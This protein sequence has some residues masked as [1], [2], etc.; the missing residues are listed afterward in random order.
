MWV[1][2]PFAGK[3]GGISERGSRVGG[4]ELKMIQNIGMRKEFRT[5]PNSGLRSGLVS[6]SVAMVLGVRTLGLR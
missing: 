1:S 4:A 3:S 5:S 6:V 2:A